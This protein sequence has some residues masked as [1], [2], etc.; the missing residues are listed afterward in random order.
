MAATRGKSLSC[1]GTCTRR[2]TKVWSVNTSPGSCT[3]NSSAISARTPASARTRSFY[4]RCRFR[5]TNPRSRSVNLYTPTRLWFRTTS[6]LSFN[7]MSR[8]FHKP[9]KSWTC[10]KASCRLNATNWS[11]RQSKTTRYIRSLTTTL[12]LSKQKGSCSCRSRK[13]TQTV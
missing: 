5:T 13:S 8:L 11:S 1:P 9:T 2:G 6:R 4:L 10:S 7:T 3:P 12:P